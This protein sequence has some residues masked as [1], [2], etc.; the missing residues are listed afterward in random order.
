MGGGGSGVVAEGE[1][2]ALFEEFAPYE[3]R[4]VLYI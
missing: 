4:Q 2:G 1:D 3:L